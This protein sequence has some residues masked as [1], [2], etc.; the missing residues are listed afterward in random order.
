VLE[1][2]DL[3]L[4]GDG[5]RGLRNVSFRV[6]AGEI[7]GLAGVAGNGQDELFALLAGLSQA[8][9]G[10]ITIKGVMTAGLSPYHVARLGVGYVPSDRFGDGLVPDFSIAENVILGQQWERRWRTGHFSNLAAIAAAGERAIETYNIVAASRAV[11]SRRLSGG[12]AQ[13]VILAREFAK[14]RQLLLCHQPTRGLDVGMTE[15]VHAEL[16]RKRDEG[17]AI[18]L[19]SEELENLLALCD[20]IAV[21]FGG[22]LLAILPRDEANVATIGRLMAGHRE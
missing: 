13:K 14:A 10:K 9:A 18:L 16:L 17:N 6:A 3:S 4:T 21:M 5:R 11:A 2:S 20:R 22:E 19:A 12:N 7:L 15:F 8:T 1:V